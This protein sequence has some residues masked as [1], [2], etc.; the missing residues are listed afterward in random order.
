[1]FSCG[2]MTICG[3]FQPSFCP[4][5]YAST[6]GAKSVP[7]LAKR[8]SM[9][10]AAS[11]PSQASA[12]V[13][14]L[15]APGSVFGAAG[16]SHG[17]ILG[18]IFAAAGCGFGAGAGWDFGCGASALGVG[19]GAGWDFACGASGLGVGAGSGLAAGFVSA[20]GRI[21]MVGSSMQRDVTP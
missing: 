8:Y 15:K 18:S 16:S 12:A 2:T 21:G 17:S 19:A 10:R 11:R 5:A 3:S 7:P 6:T 20:S 4:L 9:P 14:G 13:S 1:M